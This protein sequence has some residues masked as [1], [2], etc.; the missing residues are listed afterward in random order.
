MCSLTQI[1]SVAVAALCFM[2][3]CGCGRAPAQP[4]RPQAAPSASVPP[5]TTRTGTASA[6]VAIDRGPLWGRTVD[7][8][9]PAGKLDILGM[10]ADASGNIFVLGSRELGFSEERAWKSEEM[11]VWSPKRAILLTKLDRGGTTLWSR[12]FSGASLEKAR[13]LPAAV[14]VDS[15]GN[16]V[17]GGG[18]QGVID[19][20]GGELDSG[21]LRISEPGA[22]VAKL[23]SAGD[24]IF[25]R[26]YG[27]RGEQM[28]TALACDEQ[29]NTIVA[30]SYQRGLSLPRAD[31]AAILLEGGESERG[32]VAKLDTAGN[33]LWAKRVGSSAKVLS[34]ALG[35]EGRILIGGNYRGL[36][37]LGA[38]PLVASSKDFLGNAFVAELDAMGSARWSDSLGIEGN[39]EQ[40][41][42]VSV[43]NEQRVI[44]ALLEG[45]LGY[46]LNIV[47]FAA[48][49]GER[50]RISAGYVKRWAFASS[51]KALFVASSGGEVPASLRALSPTGATLWQQQ[52]EAPLL[53]FDPS[54]GL[55]VASGSRL[56]RI[57]TD[58]HWGS[59][60]DMPACTTEGRC[61]NVDGHCQ[62]ARSA[63]CAKTS[64]CRNEGACT[65]VGGQ[66]AVA[67]DDDCRLTVGCEYSGACGKVEKGCKATSA[68]DCERSS[69]CKE[70]G[71]CGLIGQRCAPTSTA[72]CAKSQACR[73]YGKCGWD[74]GKCRP[75]TNEHCRNAAECKGVGACEYDAHMEQC[76]GLDRARCRASLSCRNHGSCG[77]GRRELLY[78]AARCQPAS[79]ADCRRSKDCLERGACTFGR[80]EIGVGDC[81]LNSD[82]DCRRSKACKLLGY[83]TKVS[84]PDIGA[85]CALRSAADCK[86]TTGCKREGKCRLHNRRCVK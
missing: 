70:D 57:G 9:L 38:G 16:V 53:A 79:T 60:A 45:N 26:S 25:S 39:G 75:T 21:S 63:D 65:A 23:S 74:Q 47:G 15:A 85:Q 44:A 5:A 28:V 11:R 35:A 86:H 12:R 17:F 72:H 58:G 46:Q 3:A 20:G 64:R 69:N 54:G 76:V 66:C 49:Q 34:L 31:G 61:V 71:D 4:V 19:F 22:F 37:D 32:F 84:Y 80:N 10:A 62:A 24:H 6:T 29:N 78:G 36:L 30:G 33:T 83:C 13:E 48:G 73:D 42:L 2:F 51:N 1:G 55:L 81:R 52:L 67:S 14:A 27:G 43:D 59:C 50:F 8:G 56:A 77:P 18:F 7:F 41:V 82:A 40:A 68:A